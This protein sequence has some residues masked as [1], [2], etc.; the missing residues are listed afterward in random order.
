MNPPPRPTVMRLDQSVPEVYTSKGP[1][2]D[3]LSTIKETRAGTYSRRV[4]WTEKEIGV[5]LLIFTS[6]QE[7]NTS[8][9][10]FYSYL[11]ICIDF[12]E[13]G[14]IIFKELILRRHQTF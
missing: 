2:G 14:F 6:L 9:G 7:I 4:Q 1:R 3:S 13:M 11:K 5:Q 12:M 8:L 10:C